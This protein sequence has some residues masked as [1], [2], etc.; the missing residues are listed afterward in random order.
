MKSKRRFVVFLV[1]LMTVLVHPLKAQD[2]SNAKEVDPFTMNGS[3]GLNTSFYNASGG[4]PDRQ[5]PL[6][7]GL[8]AMATISAYGINMPFS[9]TWYNNNKAG[10]RHPF[11]QFGISPTYK[12]LTVHLGYRNMSFSEFT[13][14]GFTFLGAGV[15]ARPGKFRLGAVYGKFNQNS[16]YDLAMADS[17]PKLTRTGWATKLGYGTDDRFV[18]VSLLRIGDNPKNYVDS[19]AHYGQA[20][21]A[22]NLA[23][24]LTSSF[25]I[26]P[27]LFFNFD[28]SMSF[29]TNNRL[30]EES[31]SIANG[32]LRFASNFIT[33][34][35]TSE[36]HKALKTGFSYRFTPTLVS[37]FEYRRVDPGFQSMGSYFFNN[38]LEMYTFNQT[39]SF[40]QNKI[41]TRGSIGF[42]RDNLNG[43]KAKSA[44]RTIGS[45]S[46]NYAINQAWAVDAL[47][48][49]FS[50]NQKAIR[51]VTND[52][53]K[54]SQVNHN[55]SLMP[56]FTKLSETSSQMVMLNLNWMKLNDKNKLTKDQSNTD[57][58]MAMLMYNVGLLKS[59]L[60]ISAGLNSTKMVNMNYNNQLRGGNLNLAKSLLQ[61]KL[62]M[63]WNNAFMFNKINSENGT[64]FN[65]GINANYSFKSQQAVTINI[66]FINNSFGDSVI[67][68]SFKEIRG[69][70]GYVYSF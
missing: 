10:F 5:A 40:L 17:I 66:N 27:K 29:F 46:G 21:P 24:G 51:S 57:T 13:L 7:F 26:T 55:L 28:G 31:D 43:M 19:L 11:N 30:L 12:W 14:N 18:D 16:A 60:N 38:D 45:L 44:K 70:I 4:I 34:N 15:E 41:N 39:A 23:I 50:T 68:P 33:V 20:T 8:N 22:Q 9:F 35:N 1:I 32:K 37:G 36:Y 42:Q 53:L 64:I 58:F 48:S 25:K 49:N 63:S 6:A 62:S 67:V 59:K 47:Y 56:R 61:D 52:S 3:I 65:T 54:I 69:D 2:L